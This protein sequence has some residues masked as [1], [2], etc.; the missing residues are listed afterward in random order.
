VPG[1]AEEA[2]AKLWSSRET[3]SAHLRDAAAAQT[4]LAAQT[5]DWLARFVE[6]PSS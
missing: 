6:G 2:V 3:L 1:T 4:S 5:F